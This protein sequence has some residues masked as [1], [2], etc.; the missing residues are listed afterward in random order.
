MI[1]DRIIHLLPEKFKESLG[2]IQKYE[3]DCLKIRRHYNAATM[4]KE[5]ELSS[6]LSV[7]L[8]NFSNQSW[9]KHSLGDRDAHY[10]ID[11]DKFDEMVQQTIKYKKIIKEYNSNF[12]NIRKFIAWLVKRE[13]FN[14]NFELDFEE[15][16]QKHKLKANIESNLL[17][18]VTH[19]FEEKYGQEAIFCF[20]IGRAV[21]GK[22]AS[23]PRILR[24]F[25]IGGGLKTW[26]Q[27]YKDAFKVGPKF[28]TE[29]LKD[30]PIKRALTARILE[31]KAKRL[32]ESLDILTLFP[33]N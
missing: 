2:F 16:E 32:D 31:I 6:F 1:D 13:D 5:V 10:H 23:G 30:E 8:Q 28:L 15:K 12:G 21:A 26:K 4:N 19:N 24:D 22:N 27:N 25:G 18:A 3:N 14:T 11:P 29:K 9:K 20:S 33:Y 17:Q 7:E